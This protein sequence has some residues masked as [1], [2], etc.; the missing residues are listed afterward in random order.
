VVAGEEVEVGE[1]PEVVVAQG[2]VE[3][4]ETLQGLYM[5]Q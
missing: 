3:E 2:E 5:L 1:V 4:E